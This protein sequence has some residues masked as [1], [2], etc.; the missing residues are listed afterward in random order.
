MRER[1]KRERERDR[2]SG[3][4]QRGKLQDVTLI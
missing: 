3:V 2:L 1:E 4:C